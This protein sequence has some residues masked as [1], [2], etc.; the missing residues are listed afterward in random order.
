MF[1]PARFPD[2]LLKFTNFDLVFFFFS[3]LVDYHPEIAKNFEVF[4]F[5]ILSNERK[6]IL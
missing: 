3:H 6:I 4:F 1:I 2:F 5:F